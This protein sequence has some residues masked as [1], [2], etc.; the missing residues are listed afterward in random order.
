MAV[1]TAVAM[2]DYSHDAE[3]TRQ[4]ALR[5]IAWAR[6]LPLYAQWMN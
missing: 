5:L 4:M 6:A 1:I 3:Y 2:D